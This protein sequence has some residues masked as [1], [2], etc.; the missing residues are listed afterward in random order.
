MPRKREKSKAERAI[1]QF[2]DWDRADL[3]ELSQI[4]AALA[5]ASDEGAVDDEG[6]IARSGQRGSIELKMISGCGP[7]RYLRYWSGGRHRSVYLGKK[8]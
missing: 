8:P 7:Y 5:E 3:L 1:P 4:L 2:I 6:A